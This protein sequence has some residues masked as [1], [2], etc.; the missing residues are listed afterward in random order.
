LHSFSGFKN[1]PI[2]ETTRKTLIK[3]LKLA[4]EKSNNDLRK[5]SSIVSKYS[6]EEEDDESSYTNH[7]KTTSTS[8]VS[9]VFINDEIGHPKS[10]FAN[11]NSS[12]P[13]NS[14]TFQRRT[15]RNDGY[16]N[17]ENLKIKDCTRRLLQFRKTNIQNGNSSG[18]IRSSTSSLGAQR[19]DNVNNNS[20]ASNFASVVQNSKRN[21]NSAKQTLVPMMLIGFFICFFIFL[22]FMYINMSPN[23]EKNFYHSISFDK[24]CPLDD[25]QCIDESKMDSMLNLLKIITEKLQ[26]KSSHVCKRSSDEVNVWCVT[27]ILDYLN[28]AHDMIEREE[29]AGLLQSLQ[30]LIDR[31][32]LLGIS[33]VDKLGKKFKIQENL[34][35]HETCFALENQKSS[36]LY[37]SFYIKANTFFTILGSLSILGILAFAISKFHKFVIDLKIKRQHQMEQMIDTIMR[38]VKDRASME[39]EKFVVV[40]YMKDEIL[41]Q[42]RNS[43]LCWAWTNALEY[44]EKNDSRLHF[45]LKNVNGEDLKIIQWVQAVRKDRNDSQDSFSSSFKSSNNSKFESHGSKWLG[46]AFDKSNR[47]KN[48]PT[49]CLKIRSMFEK[50]EIENPNLS[51]F[52][53]DNIFM[54]VREKGCKILAIELDKKTCCV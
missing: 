54:K 5:K 4:M 9:P 10:F 15:G 35:L 24:N 39:N 30:Y 52:I 37:C 40:N 47:I 2:T 21:L 36:P 51:A 14:S 25:T 17:D 18:G 33:N 53:R 19:S 3:K 48:P 22:I 7:R 12:L 1:I 43:E 26:T 6:S 16:D 41:M 44:L 46:P 31:N 11:N 20:F 13:A 27:E 34:N 8:Y 38:Y 50:H 42:D 45:G 28:N 49:N 29:I 32:S 23:I